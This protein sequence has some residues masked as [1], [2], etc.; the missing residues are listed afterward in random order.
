MDFCLVFFRCVWVPH[1]I[2]IEFLGLPVDLLLNSHGFRMVYDRFQWVFY[3]FLWLPKGLLRFPM[4]LLF[5]PMVHRGFPVAFLW[6]PIVAPLVSCCSPMD[7]LWLPRKSLME[8]QWCSID[9]LGGSMKCPM[10]PTE[11]RWLSVDVLWF[12]TGP[13][14]VSNGFL[15]MCHDFRLTS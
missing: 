13:W 8:V 7:F 6:F 15:K 1:W 14:S 4:H 12:A 2:P 3:G 9:S 10:C 11:S 5:F